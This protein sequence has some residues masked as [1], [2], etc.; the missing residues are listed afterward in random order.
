MNTDSR[1]LSAKLCRRRIDSPRKGLGARFSE[2]HW[3]LRRSRVYIL[4]QPFAQCGRRPQT[5]RQTDN[6]FEYICTGKHAENNAT[7]LVKET[8]N[9]ASMG[10]TYKKLN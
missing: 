5:G 9:V 4:S 3:S 6:L 2:Q 1:R 7:S 10:A 8:P